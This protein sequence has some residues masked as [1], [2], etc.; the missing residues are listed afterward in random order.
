LLWT[1]SKLH[2]EALKDS[3]FLTLTYPAGDREASGCKRHL[4]SFIKR[5]KRRFPASA[6]MWKMEYTKRETPHFH[7][8]LLGIPFWNRR[9]V[10][11]SWAEIVS[12]AN[13]KHQAAGTRIERLNNS[14]HALRY[15][16][17]YMAKPHPAPATHRGR[18]WG[19]TQSLQSFFSAQQAWVLSQAQ[20]L[21]LRRVLD[22]LRHSHNRSRTFKRRANFEITQRWFARGPDIL[23]LAAFLNLDPALP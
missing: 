4:D 15:L 10:A 18:F 3:L 19:F 7:L 14:R 2:V 22:K 12:S 20:T 13:P 5:L 9:Q 6:A 21:T 11:S 16:C 1:C 23:R 8:L 17:K